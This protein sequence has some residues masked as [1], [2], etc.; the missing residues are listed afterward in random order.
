VLHVIWRSVIVLLNLELEEGKPE[1]FI[2]IFAE[3]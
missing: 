3:F 1:E 2:K